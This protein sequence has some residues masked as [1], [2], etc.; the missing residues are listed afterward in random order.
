MKVMI[1]SFSSRFCLNHFDLV[2]S[3]TQ[4]L[5]HPVA[6][7]LSNLLNTFHSAVQYPISNTL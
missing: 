4:W 6:I 5:F 7:L 1:V 3:F 2:V